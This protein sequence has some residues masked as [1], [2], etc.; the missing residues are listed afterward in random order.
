M[1]IYFNFMLYF[2]P[3]NIFLYQNTIYFT[4]REKILYLYDEKLFHIC[5]DKRK[6]FSFYL[7]RQ[8]NI[9]VF[10][11]RILYIFHAFFEIFRALI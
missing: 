1:F 2:P 7:F 9:N 10:K 8:N 3:K 11:M 4:E 6:S 5:F